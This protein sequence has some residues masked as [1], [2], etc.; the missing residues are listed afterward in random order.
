MNNTTVLYKVVATTTT[1]DNKEFMWT[2]G[3]LITGMMALIGIDPQLGKLL[4]SALV[5]SAQE[6]GTSGDGGWH[7]D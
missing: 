6:E 4:T 5:F 3:L 2:A 1:S 7:D